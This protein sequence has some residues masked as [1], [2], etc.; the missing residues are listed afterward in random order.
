M[1]SIDL[2]NTE[3][4]KVGSID[5][6][7]AVFGAEVKPHLFYAVVRY[8]LAKRRAG[9][10]ATRSRAQVSGGGKKPYR[11]KGTGRARQGTTRA[12]HWR[13][14][15]VVH[16]PHPRSHAHKLPKKVRRAALRSALSKRVQDEAVT[17][18]D[19]F[20]LPEVKTR[21]FAK[22]M[23]TFDFDD[24]LL[25]LPERDEAIV[26]SARNIPGVTVLPVEGLNVYDVLKHKNLAMTKDAVDGVVAR[27]GR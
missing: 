2:Y 5:L 4:E 7:D 9:T 19:G 23:K 16:G 10:H 18:F 8:Q 12:V 6:D 26:R 15:G 25:V 11:Q 14:G 13:G 17:V 27:L 21:A 20:Q 3:R 1:P 22:V 24:L